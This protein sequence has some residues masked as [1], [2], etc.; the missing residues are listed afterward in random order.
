MSSSPAVSIIGE[1]RITL[2]APMTR[3]LRGTGATRMLLL[4]D[5]GQRKI[6]L[7]APLKGRA[8]RDDRSYGICYFLNQRQDAIGAQL[9]VK[10]IGWDERLR[11]D[12][13][14]NSTTT[15]SSVAEA[16]AS[17]MPR[18]SLAGSSKRNRHS[19]R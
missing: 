6:G 7:V 11:Y 14:R 12:N 10:E 16:I 13:L 1:G 4:F 5:E 15:C 2:N 18:D 8:G 19:W 9:F 17:A 3:I